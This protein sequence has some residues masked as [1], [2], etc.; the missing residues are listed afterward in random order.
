MLQLQHEH[1][2]TRR[3]QTLQRAFV[4]LR[5]AE[6]RWCDGAIARGLRGER[7][8][9]RVRSQYG[10]GEETEQRRYRR[11]V[12]AWRGKRLVGVQDGEEGGRGRDE[13]REIG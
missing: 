3:S 2:R 1:A 9:K 8:R 10:G 7:V 13:R 5:E 4:V 12:G 11:A 6:D